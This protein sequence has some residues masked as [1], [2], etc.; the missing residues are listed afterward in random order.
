VSYEMFVSVGGKSKSYAAKGNSITGEMKNVL[1][2]MKPGQT[3]I[4][5]KMV[6]K[7]DKPGTSPRPLDGNIIIHVK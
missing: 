4:F 3:V 1:K 7:M 6:A 2:T 5:Q